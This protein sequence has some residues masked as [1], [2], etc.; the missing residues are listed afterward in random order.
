MTYAVLDLDARTMTFARAGH[1]PLM[2]LPGCGAADAS[3]GARTRRHGR[4]PEASTAPARSSPSCSKRRRIA[5]EPGD[6]FV[7]LHRRHH[8]SDERRRGSVRRG[9][10][11]PLVE[12][13]GH[14]TSDELRE[15]IV[16][17]VQAFVGERR[18]ARRH[19][20]DSASRSSRGASRR[21]SESPYEAPWPISSGWRDSLPCITALLAGHAQ[22]STLSRALADLVIV[23]GAH[24]TVDPSRP[25][26][27]AVAVC[28]DRIGRVGTNEDIRARLARSTR[29]IDAGGPARRSG[30]NDAHV[31]LIDG[32]DELLGVDLRH[33]TSAQDVARRLGATRPSQP[34]GRWILGGFWDHEAWPGKALPDRQLVD[35]SP[36]DNPVFVQRLDGHMGVANALALQLRRHRR[37]TRGAGRRRDRSDAVGRAH[38]HPQG[39]RDGSRHPRRSRRHRSSRRSTRRAPALR[40]RPRS[41]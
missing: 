2:Y 12:E 9:A 30:F 13:H 37:A 25:W 21:R 40:T 8:R 28:G 3:A 33:A 36:P 18:A 26:A 31:H 27:E 29:V 19:D 7:L 6:V 35:A 11:R 5:L 34:K 20:D 23:N 32:A 15:R 41:A 14:L 24:H 1:T 10:A 4:R 17:E 39:Q 22:H 16:R 38:R